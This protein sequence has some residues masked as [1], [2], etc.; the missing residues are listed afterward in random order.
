M[1]IGSMPML[2][3]FLGAAS[4]L[5]ALAIFV[6]VFQELYKYVTSSKS[7]TYLK[8]LIDFAGPWAG[9]L[10][11]SG[12]VPDFATR[13]PFQFLQ[14]RPPNSLLPLEKSALSDAVVRTAPDWIQRALERLEFEASLQN[15]ESQAPSPSWRGFAEELFAAE[16]GSRGYWVATRVQELLERWKVARVSKARSGASR[17]VHARSLDAAAVL[18]ALKAEL[19]PHLVDLEDN[20]EQLTRNFDYAYQRRNTRQ[21]FVIAIVLALCCNF[22]FDRIFREASALP[23]EA[24]IA[25]AEAMVGHWEAVSNVGAPADQEAFEDQLQDMQAA[26]AHLGDLA[27]ES[28]QLD[29][30]LDLADLRAMWDDK[31]MGVRYLFGC[32]ITAILVSFGAPLLHDLTRLLLGLQKNWRKRPSAERGA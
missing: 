1:T 9:Q 19:L 31:W 15:G 2:T 16:R 23:P 10:V 8:A 5:L 21:T 11:K 25:A 7:K 32:L 18:R 6:Q 24:A 27:S 29:Y 3:T 13:G 14:I 12:K 20:H 22:P 17:V 30:L 4:Y 26:I 28:G